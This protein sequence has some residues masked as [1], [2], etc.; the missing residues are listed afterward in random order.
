MTSFSKDHLHKTKPEKIDHSLLLSCLY[1]E[2]SVNLSSH[3]QQLNFSTQAFICSV[4][5]HQ[6][7]CLHSHPQQMLYNSF[8]YSFPV[9]QMVEHGASNAKIVGSIP[10]ES[11][12]W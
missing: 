10:R 5:S 4:Q 3:S 11:K 9:A 7:H 12:G 8:I 2:R 1:L 6:L